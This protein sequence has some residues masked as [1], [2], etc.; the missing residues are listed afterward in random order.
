[1]KHCHKCGEPIISNYISIRDVCASCGTDLH[2]CLNCTFYDRGSYNECREPQ[3]EWEGR[4]G[5]KQLLR[6]L[7]VQ[8]GAQDRELRGRDG[9]GKGQARGPF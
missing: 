9:R 8:S 2:T 5:S 3:S 7:S 1:M 6:F 4:K